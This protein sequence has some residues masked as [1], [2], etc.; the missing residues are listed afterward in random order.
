MVAF[1]DGYRTHRRHTNVP[2]N[3]APK[4]FASEIFGKGSSGTASSGDS[5]ACRA[6]MVAPGAWK[7]VI[8]PEVLYHQGIRGAFGEVG[9]CIW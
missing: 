1:K 7:I 9:V 5:G 6:S 4:V 3:T 2:S 8:Y